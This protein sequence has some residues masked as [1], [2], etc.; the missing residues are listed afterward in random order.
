MTLLSRHVASRYLLHLVVIA[1]L[2][3]GLYVAVDTPERINQSQGVLG[4]IPLVITHVLPVAAG[5][6]VLTAIGALRA[7]GAITLLRASGVGM[8]RILGPVAVAGL[9]AAV[10]EAALCLFLAPAALS[11]GALAPDGAAPAWILHQ[12]RILHRDAGG[13]FTWHRPSEPPEE[14]GEM[15]TGGLDEDLAVL[16]SRAPA[17]RTSTLRLLSV[18]R[19]AG[20]MGHDSRAERVELW[21]RSLLPIALIGAVATCLVAC[22]RR[23]PA[24]RGAARLVVAVFAC[25]LGLAVATQ[26]FMNGAAQAWVMLALP[27]ALLGACTASPWP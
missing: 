5:A 12:G 25:F 8:A 15:D 20:R 22:V 3:S 9:A 7:S 14:A 13:G 27:A 24:W 16:A 11:A 21:T 2:L 19:V 23:R 1:S 18:A 26:L 10:V 17:E 4:R 6:A